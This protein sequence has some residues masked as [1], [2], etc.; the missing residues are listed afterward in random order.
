MLTPGGA[1]RLALER[2]PEEFIELA[3]DTERDQ[4]AVMLRSTR[5]RG[6]RMVSS[7]R[8]AREGSTIATLTQED[9][10]GLLL[11]ELVPFIER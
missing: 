3:L 10:V 11:D 5:G 9:V 4:P 2:S 1:A 6:R 7:E 8:V